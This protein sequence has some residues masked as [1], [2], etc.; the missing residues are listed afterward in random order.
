MPDCPDGDR[1]LCVLVSEGLDSREGSKTGSDQVS[2]I[3]YVHDSR[4][5]Y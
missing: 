4:E 2:A 5:K 1:S 3:S